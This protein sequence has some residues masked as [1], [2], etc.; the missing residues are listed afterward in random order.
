MLR[1]ISDGQSGANLA[2]L[3]AAYLYG[4]PT[5]GT[6][7]KGWR[8][9]DPQGNETTNPGLEKFGLVESE[10]S[11]YPSRT[12][13]NVLNSDITL[14]FGNTSSPG[15]TK[16]EYI[17]LQAE[18]RVVKNPDYEKVGK[19]IKQHRSWVFNITGNREHI[20]RGIGRKTFVTLI[21]AFSYAGFMAMDER[22]D[23]LIKYSV[24]P[25]DLIIQKPIF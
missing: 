22:A 19:Y 21:K 6:A 17:C 9:Y 4:I 11:K 23:T 12:K 10:S 2:G 15:S 16:T 3:Y 8:V 1:I 5:G 18:K 14:L 24:K 7:S 13:Q 25:R 20:N